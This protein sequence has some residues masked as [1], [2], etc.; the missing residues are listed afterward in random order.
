MTIRYTKDSHVVLITID[1]YEKRN[2]LDLEH[3]SELFACWKKFRDDPDAWVAIVT[4]V[5]NAFCSGGD[6]AMIADI[7]REQAAFGHSETR[8]RLNNDGEGYFTLKGFDLFK[9]VIAAVNGSCMAG[10]MEL[11]MGTDIRLASEQ[12]I[13]GVSEPL[14]GIMAAGGTTAR[15]PRQMGWAASMEMLLTARPIDAER[16]LRLGLIN[17]VVPHDELIETARRW[18]A[19]ICRNSPMAVQATKRSAVLGLAAGSLAEAFAIEDACADELLG[20]QD[21]QEGARAYL[22]KRP[23]IWT[24]G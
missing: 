8:A 21:A 13:F 24:G 19:E 17:E 22:E 20:T 4:G 6:M 7:A 5:Q 9:P 14:R 10:G 15:M 18:A 1:R 16:A 12:A 3:A 23:P 11:L 2:A